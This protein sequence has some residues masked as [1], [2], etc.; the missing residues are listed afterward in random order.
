[1]KSFWE[2]H[3]NFLTHNSSSEDCYTAEKISAA[4][5]EFYKDGSMENSLSKET[6]EIIGRYL[7]EL[8][9]ATDRKDYITANEAAV[10]SSIRIDPNG[11][12]FFP[13]GSHITKELTQDTIFLD[14]NIIREL[15]KNIVEN[16]HSKNSEMTTKATL[17]IKLSVKI[18]KSGEEVQD[19]SQADQVTITIE[20][21]GC[22]CE[23]LSAIAKNTQATTYGKLTTEWKNLI[24]SMGSIELHSKSKSIE[25]TSDVGSVMHSDFSEGFKTVINI[26]TQ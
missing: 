21:N 23:D 9:K 1:M 25:Y 6:F 4:N 7:D 3:L 26:R 16:S 14:A 10:K 18:L 17:K 12:N 24:H 19:L 22:G 2:N 8:S 20:D 15:I 13:T 11:W 5:L